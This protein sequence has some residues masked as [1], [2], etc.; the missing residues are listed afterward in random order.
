MRY[1]PN[2]KEMKKVGKSLTDLPTRLVVWMIR[3]FTGFQEM[4]M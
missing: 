4:Q 1:A 2:P 3:I